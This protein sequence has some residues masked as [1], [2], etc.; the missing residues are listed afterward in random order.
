MSWTIEDKTCVITG[1]SDGIGLETARELAKRRARVY[2]VC[3]NR[4]K[5]EPLRLE[6]SR[7]AKHRAE[8][9]IA[10]L[11][12]HAGVKSAA[13][14]L[15]AKCSRIDVLI[16][17]AGAIFTER[18][19]TADGL[20]QTFALNHLAYFHLTK[21]LLDRVKASAPARIINVASHAHRREVL[22]LDD[23]QSEKSWSGRVTYGRSKLMNVLFT[24]E[25]AR[26]LEGSG[27]TANCLHPGVIASSF[28]LEAR[29]LVGAFFS[30]ARPFLASTKAG[31]KTTLRLACAPELEGV[32]GQYFA[33]EKVTESSH[34]SKDRATA[35]K[36]WE[37]SDALLRGT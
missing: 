10:D 6:L 3:R 22:D 7:D 11:S 16:N 27:V 5:S 12:T 20:E 35:T 4:E 34:P 37:L 25:L 14:E 30:L 36:L 18:K 1:A 26:R 28:G 23:L 33:A 9:V 32:T 24:Y 31:A 13:A 8:L 17:N 19:T 15:L 29:G 2:M 21:L